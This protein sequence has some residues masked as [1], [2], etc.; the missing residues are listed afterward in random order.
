MGKLSLATLAIMY[1]AKLE[2]MAEQ[3]LDY[4]PALVSLSDYS[5]A[6]LERMIRMYERIEGESK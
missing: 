4:D 6:E 5:D 1:R 3:I 2:E